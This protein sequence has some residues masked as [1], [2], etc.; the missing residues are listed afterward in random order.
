MD[1]YFSQSHPTPQLDRG[2]PAR[3]DDSSST[4]SLHCR[5]AAVPLS[6]LA[7]RLLTAAS[8]YPSDCNLH[9][10]PA[11]RGLYSMTRIGIAD[12]TDSG[13]LELLACAMTHLCAQESTAACSLASCACSWPA[14]FSLEPSALRCSASCFCRCLARA[15]ACFVSASA[16]VYIWSDISDE[17]MMISAEPRILTPVLS[18]WNL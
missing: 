10:E 4:R 2:L 15:S 7:S 16:F 6:T 13:S 9:K 8:S 18:H 5:T 12:S 11:L 1:V 17:L 14:S 3:L